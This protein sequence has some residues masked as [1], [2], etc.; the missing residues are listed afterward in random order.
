MAVWLTKQ[1]PL[2]TLPLATA[3]SPTDEELIAPACVL[4]F[5]MLPSNTDVNA[6]HASTI[7]PHSIGFLGQASDQRVNATALS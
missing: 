5:T 4:W 2:T 1:S 6:E 7:V 3:S